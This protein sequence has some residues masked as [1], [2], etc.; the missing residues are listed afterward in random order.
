MNF[1]QI[2]GIGSGLTRRTLLTLEAA[3]ERKHGD[4]NNSYSDK[5]AKPEIGKDVPVAPAAA[6]SRSKKPWQSD[7]E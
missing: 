1:D 4:P 2:A 7:S 3:E 6:A 5:L